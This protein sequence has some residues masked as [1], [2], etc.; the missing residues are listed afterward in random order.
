MEKPPRPWVAVA[1]QKFP[2]GEVAIRTLWEEA[3]YM[4]A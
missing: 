1:E 2:G 4:C 3:H